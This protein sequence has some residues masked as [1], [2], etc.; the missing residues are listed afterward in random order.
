MGRPGG[1]TDRE[2]QRRHR[3]HRRGNH[4]LCHPERCEALRGRQTVPEP[5][6]VRPVRVTPV[7]RDTGDGDEPD[8][9]PIA[10]AVADALDTAPVL[11]RDAGATALAR[12][13][14]A[15]LDEAAPAS[16]YREPLDAIREA[17]D[18]LYRLD[19]LV[20][21]QLD[22]PFARIVDA[23]G[24]HSVA[25]DLGP[26]LLAVLTA[27]GMTAAGRSAKGGAP[28]GPKVPDQLGE[29]RMRAQQRRTGQH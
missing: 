13:Y 12:R 2:R 11:P 16:K 25:S 18:V 19:P 8:E 6:P 22:K 7:T 29:L 28:D 15:L 26:K 27:L 14:A 4:D 3:A 9:G 10:R 1:G 5:A 24:A 23:L 20:A 21:G 17:I